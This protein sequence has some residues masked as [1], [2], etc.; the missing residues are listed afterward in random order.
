MGI[1]PRSASDFLTLAS[2]S[3]WVLV[4]SRTAHKRRQSIVV[5]TR[6]PSL[7]Q[8]AMRSW[9]FKQTHET[10]QRFQDVPILTWRSAC[11]QRAVHPSPQRSRWPPRIFSTDASFPRPISSF[12]WL[13]CHLLVH[14]DP[15]K[16]PGT[17]NPVHR[18]EQGKTEERGW[19][20][21]SGN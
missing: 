20:L 4:I 18:E 3:S 16:G 17:E 14:A 8:C 5:A 1:F 13:T 19:P 11:L 21:P 10:S 15:G 2:A 7:P 6:F 12:S 9:F